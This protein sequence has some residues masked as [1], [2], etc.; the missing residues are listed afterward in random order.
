[1]SEFP[2]PNCPHC[3]AQLPAGA[4]VCPT[5][6]RLVFEQRLAQLFQ[7]A[8]AQESVNPAIAARV[9]RQAL[10]MIPDGSNEHQMIAAR[11]AALGGGMFAPQSGTG[12]TAMLDYAPPERKR[13]T[14]TSALLKT[15][16]SMALSMFVYSTFLGWPFAVGFV[17]LI[18]IHELGHTLANWA[19]GIKQSPPIFIPFMGALIM[20]RQNPKDAKAEAVIG[21]AGPIAGTFG[22]LCCFALYLYTGQPLLF[23]LA[24]Y[25]ILMNLFNLI[26]IWP[27]DGGRV[28]A[29]ITPILWIPGVALFGWVMLQSGGKSSIPSILIAFWI[30]QN[31]LPR[32]RNVIFRGGMKS[33]YY[34]IGAPARLAILFSYVMLA[35]VLT[36]MGLSSATL[37]AWIPGLHGGPV[38]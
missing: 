25:A 14:V 8:Q 29:G 13:E 3:G 10:P 7:E 17:L 6:H 11:A 23:L 34:R 21:I 26:P 28:A 18:L 37:M 38:R 12:R 1:M 36:L 20:L 33:D 27:L 31:T 22:A 4:L 24:K 2:I 5:C 32:I 35:A 19:Y 15:G 16:G 30:F 9:W